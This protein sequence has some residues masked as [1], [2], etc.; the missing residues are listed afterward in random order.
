MLSPYWGNN[1]LFYGLSFKEG[2]GLRIIWEQGIRQDIFSGG[3]KVHTWSAPVLLIKGQI[4][5]T[6]IIPVPEELQFEVRFE[7]YCNCYCKVYGVYELKSD[8]SILYVILN[9][10]GKHWPRLFESR[11][12]NLDEIVPAV[13]GMNLSFE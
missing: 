1:C 2:S 4:S 6:L 9:T 5:V 8:P 11:A 13:H 10:S 12:L 7:N 3:S